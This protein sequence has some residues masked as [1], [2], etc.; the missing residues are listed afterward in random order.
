MTAPL[1]IPGWLSDENREQLEDLIAVHDV[2]SVIEIGS[3]MG[4]SAVWFASHPQI[5]R[6]TCID[7]WYEPANY[8]SE[9]NLVATLRRWELP[10]DFFPLFRDNVM[11]SGYWHKIHP[12]RGHSRYI[13]GEAPEADL[14]YIDGDHSYEGVERDITLYRPKAKKVIAGDDFVKRYGFGVIEAV[15]EMLPNYQAVGPF[16]W[17]ILV[18]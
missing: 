2:R 6:V 4:L 10:R 3:F 7:T 15:R 5:E 16:W 8:E 17:S 1:G 13:C 18:S 11:R 12:L 14:V 9:N